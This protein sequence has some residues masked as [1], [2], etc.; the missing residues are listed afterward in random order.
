VF[1]L[2]VASYTQAYVV[3]GGSQ[4]MFFSGVAGL[5]QKRGISDWESDDDTL[6]GIGKG[7]GSTK[8]DPVQLAVYEKNW[9][10][11]DPAKVSL[12]RK[13]FGEVR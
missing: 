2:A 7:L 10:N 8:I 13:G 9:G 4:H 3:S 6:R 5:G 12:I 11:D 1:V